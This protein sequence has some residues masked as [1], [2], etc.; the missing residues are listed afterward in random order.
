MLEDRTGQGDGLYVR[1]GCGPGA[2]QQLLGVVE[3]RRVFVVEV[4]DPAMRDALI[5][6][7]APLAPKAPDAPTLTVSQ[8][9]PLIPPTSDKRSRKPRLTVT[10]GGA[11]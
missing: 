9:C 7:L 1:E 6:A 2:P 5:R 11:A 4:L 3:G 10:R 8:G